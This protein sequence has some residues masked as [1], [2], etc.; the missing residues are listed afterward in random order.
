M[1]RS[2]PSQSGATAG[3]VVYT[4]FGIA[5]AVGMIYLGSSG[6]IS[7]SLRDAIEQGNRLQNQL[8]TTTAETPTAV[9][10]PAPLPQP[11][12]TKPKQLSPRAFT[13]IYPIRVSYT[14]PAGTGTSEVIPENGTDVPV[15]PEVIK[16]ATLLP[17]TDVTSV[18][19]TDGM[20][21]YIFWNAGVE[22]E[23]MTPVEGT[24]F[25]VERQA[26]GQ[27]RW[28][29]ISGQPL[30]AT[31]FVDSNLAPG[32]AYKY[33]VRAV[34]ID[35]AELPG[36]VG[37]TVIPDAERKPVNYAYSERA[38]ASEAVSLPTPGA[39]DWW[40]NGTQR[41]ATTRAPE[42]N[43]R[44]R[45][46]FASQDRFTGVWSWH[47]IT[48]DITGLSSGQ[49]IGGVYNREELNSGQIITGGMTVKLLVEYYG[50]NG[51]VQVTEDI[52]SR[53]DQT[54]DFTT[55]L[56]FVSI[57]GGDAV[58]SGPDGQQRVSVSERDA[59]NMPAE[60]PPPRHPASG[61]SEPVGG[62]EPGD[63]EEPMPP[64]DE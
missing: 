48:L 57:A 31:H 2:R 47:R 59:K 3:P 46:W 27:D 62:D 43:V 10:S 4:I 28:Q 26:E 38:E 49:T 15:K 60:N 55:G 14:P 40:T 58:L 32:V 16:V 20:V 36:R 42:L 25:I 6:P 7:E 19:Y 24:R 23:K 35:D 52:N 53:L 11:L 5:A 12:T 54:L 21:A 34:T 37:S 33:A 45:K 64:E 18:A 13:P 50:D 61:P 56:T 1:S 9:P 29:R 63:G 51:L 8:T 22:A 41:N 30:D 44:L 39:P 17:A